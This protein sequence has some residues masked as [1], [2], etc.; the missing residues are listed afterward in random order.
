MIEPPSVRRETQKTTVHDFVDTPDH[1]EE[2]LAF[3]KRT[4]DLGAGQGRWEDRLA[5][6]WDENPF[7]H[8]HPLRGRVVCMD[9][10]I[11]GFGGAV[12]VAYALHRQ[13]LPVLLATTLRVEGEPGRA[14]AA[15]LLHM[16]EL[17]RSIPV[18]HTTP[19]GK[20]QQ[21]LWSMGAMGETQVTRRVYLAGGLRVLRPGRAWPRLDASVRLTTRPQEVRSVSRSWRSESRIEKWTTPETLRW[22]LSTPVCKQTFIGAVDAEGMLTSYLL[23]MPRTLR[24]FPA[25][26]VVESFTTRDSP[27]ELHALMGELIRHPGHLPG[28]RSLVTVATFPADTTWEGTPCI[29]TRDQTVCHFTVLPES[30]RQIPKY[31]MMAEGDLVL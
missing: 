5:H 1:R 31:T 22:Y 19:N 3:L 28:Y 30:L 16:R 27:E 26:D 20:I 2:L 15:I 6:W 23:L 7:A 14:G 18:I 4:G 24:G 9:G 8:L 11:V 17:S 10:R 21:A 29:M 12:P 13:I 25:W